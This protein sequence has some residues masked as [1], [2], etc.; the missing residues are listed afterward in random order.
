MEVLPGLRSRHWQRREVNAHEIS[1]GGKTY[2]VYLH[3]ECDEEQL[4][5]GSQ[6]SVVSIHW[7]LRDPNASL[8]FQSRFH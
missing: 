8:E 5:H 4:I 7:I 3:I 1:F 6:E 2:K